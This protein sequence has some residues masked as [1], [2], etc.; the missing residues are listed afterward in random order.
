MSLFSETEFLNV[1]LEEPK[2]NFNG[3]IFW[4]YEYKKKVTN[5]QE[6]VVNFLSSRFYFLKC[7]WFFPKLSNLY[8]YNMVKNMGKNVIIVTCVVSGIEGQMYGK[9]Q[10]FGESKEPIY[11]RMH[12]VR[13]DI[14]FSIL[15]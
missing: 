7:D 9:I 15:W 11:V 6:Y 12:I 2:S 8:L 3:M 14:F 10:R 13:I 5:G 4:L 1:Y